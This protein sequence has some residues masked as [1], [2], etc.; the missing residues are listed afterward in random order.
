[1]K[2]LFDEFLRK[3]IAPKVKIEEKD[4]QQ[5]YRSH[6]EQFKRPERYKVE[7]IFIAALEDAKPLP[8]DTPEAVRQKAARLRHQLEADA[9]VK[10]SE[11]YDKLKAGGNFEELAKE[12]SED[13]NS[14]DKGGL[15]GEMV[16]EGLYPEMAAWLKKLKPGEFSEPIKTPLG[17]HI[18]KVAE[19]LPPEAIPLDE[20][21]ADIMN[22]LL[23]E[24]VIK[25]RD[26]YFKEL[27]LSADI[28]I[29]L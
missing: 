19:H 10:V 23:R 1:M 15:L 26:A 29:H 21:K 20:V 14:K 6:L 7:H 12:Y 18:M 17:F 9:R 3:E 25:A 24:K 8:E 13:F 28:K 16:P 2:F 22:H 5:F 11:V 4:I 27:R